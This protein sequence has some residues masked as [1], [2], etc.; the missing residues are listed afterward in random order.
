[1]IYS[2]LRDQN[3]SFCCQV[4]G[5]IMLSKFFLWN[6]AVEVVEASEVIEAVEVIEAPEAPDA[7]EITQYA[8]C[9]LSFSVKRHKQ[10]KNVGKKNWKYLYIMY[11]QTLFCIYFFAL[12]QDWGCGGQGCY[13]QPNPSVIS[14]M[15]ASHE[16]T[17]MFFV[18]LKCIFDG[19]ISVLFC[20][21]RV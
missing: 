18:T 2:T 16:C 13:F 17:D 10:A 3:R 1:M 11:I 7:R 9:K 4:N 5:N 21:Y 6:E 19:L 8:K 15:S 12:I 14:Q 20:A